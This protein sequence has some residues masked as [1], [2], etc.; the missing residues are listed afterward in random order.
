M[1]DEIRKFRGSK[2]E[3]MVEVEGLALRLVDLVNRADD[4]EIEQLQLKGIDTGVWF[5]LGQALAILGQAKELLKGEDPEKVALAWEE[6]MEK[7]E[8]R[9]DIVTVSKKTLRE[10]ADRAMQMWDS[11]F[12]GGCEDWPELCQALLEASPMVHKDFDIHSFLGVPQA[13]EEADGS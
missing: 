13:E 7:K 8:A 11:G 6:L 5:L 1:N 4:Y 2:E 9:L 3:L 10:L 12:S